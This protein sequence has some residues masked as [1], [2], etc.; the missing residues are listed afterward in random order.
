MWVD[1]KGGPAPMGTSE[2]RKAM[3]DQHHFGGFGTLLRE[4]YPALNLKINRG[5][6]GLQS[7]R[8]FFA[9]YPQDEALD[10]WENNRTAAATWTLMGKVQPL[11][12]FL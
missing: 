10:D 5:G 9:L 2:K 6:V 4:T 3:T 1:G 11:Q 7:P 12:G 8:S